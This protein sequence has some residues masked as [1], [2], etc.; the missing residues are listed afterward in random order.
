MAKPEFISP[1]DASEAGA[2]GLELA[3]V[4]W[5]AL[6]RQKFTVFCPALDVLGIFGHHPDRFPSKL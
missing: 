6:Y 2:D 1:G 4:H 5:T 3:A